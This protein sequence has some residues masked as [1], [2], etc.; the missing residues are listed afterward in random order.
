MREKRDDFGAIVAFQKS[1]RAGNPAIRLDA[2]HEILEKNEEVVRVAIIGGKRGA[3]HD[4]EVDEPGAAF[5]GSEDEISRMRIAVG[6]RGPEFIAVPLVGA[7]QFAACR[8]EHFLS[9][10]ACVNMLREAAPRQFIGPYGALS[11][12]EGAVVFTEDAGNN[13]PPIAAKAPG[14]ATTAPD[15]RPCRRTGLP[16]P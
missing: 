15:S 12:A 13:R 6:P 5:V 3:V 8:C 2:A 16:A 14:R 9:D 11:A 7:M 10:R 4:L 1:T